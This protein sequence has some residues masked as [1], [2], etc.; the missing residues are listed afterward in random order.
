M[1]RIAQAHNS[2]R[3]HK[4][5]LS[6]RR[7]WYLQNK[8]CDLGLFARVSVHVCLYVPSRNSLLTHQT[9]SETHL[10]LWFRN[11]CIQ[12][13][14]V[15]VITV[16]QCPLL[17]FC[18]IF[19]SPFRAL[20][21]GF[22]FLLFLNLNNRKYLVYLHHEPIRAY[23]SEFIFNAK[24]FAFLF[25]DFVPISVLHFLSSWFRY[26]WFCRA[27]E[28]QLHFARNIKLKVSHKNGWSFQLYSTMNLDCSSRNCPLIYS[29]ICV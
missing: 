12:G 24:Q 23:C 27:N 28:Q 16:C 26:F 20:C 18:F 8:I 25:L 21:F 29:S 11:G 2:E 22:F 1:N 15:H 4:S 9:Q 17:S 19:P 7:L 3:V 13:V 6:K 10:G 14:F 5:H